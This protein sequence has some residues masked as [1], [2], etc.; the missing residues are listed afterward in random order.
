MILIVLA[1]VLSLKAAL[2][3]RYPFAVAARSPL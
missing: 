1:L 3:A 2:T